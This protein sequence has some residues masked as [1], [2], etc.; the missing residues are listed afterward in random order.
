[1]RFEHASVLR[2]VFYYS[3]FNDKVIV[4][5]KRSWVNVKFRAHYE[6]D[7]DGPEREGCGFIH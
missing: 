3:K 1:M 7:A 5:A 4:Y 6:S 2:L